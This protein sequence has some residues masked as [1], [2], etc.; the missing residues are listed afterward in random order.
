[1]DLSAI[2]LAA[3]T[4]QYLKHLREL[5]VPPEQLAAFLVVAATLL[6]LK[7]RKL[8]PELRLSG[9]EEER[10]V[11]LEEQLREY[12]AFREAAKGLG[13]NWNRGVLLYARASFQ[14]LLAA[15]YPPP[16]LGPRELR[17]AI[18]RVLF[19]LPQVE[20]LAEDVWKHVVSLEER[21]KDIQQRLVSQ[22]STSF[23]SLAG[24]SSSKLEV[25]VSF[26]A[27]L[28]LVKQQIVAVEQH[29]A[30]RDILLSRQIVMPPKSEAL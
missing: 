30:F 16:D 4:D 26:L 14:N 24:R 3:V 28:E 10:M 19:A 2:S 23:S 17:T 22:V 29:G 8:F 20:R 9:Q 5:R 1:M 13:L 12:R 18:D 7:S 6:L 21:A 11:S 27:L 25:I 15:F